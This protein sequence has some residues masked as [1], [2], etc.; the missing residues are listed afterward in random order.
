MITSIS[1]DINI[2]IHTIAIG[3]SINTG[4]NT[5]NNITISIHTCISIRDCILRLKISVHDLSISVDVSINIRIN[6]RTTI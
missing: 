1:G 5:C 4:S 3:K 6:I 2:G